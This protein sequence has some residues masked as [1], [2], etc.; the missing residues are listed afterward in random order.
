MVT[1]MPA[2]RISGPDTRDRLASL[3]G[4]R[5]WAALVVVLYH[6]SRLTGKLPLISDV[7]W[8]GRTGVTFFFVLSGFVLAWT[9]DGK[10]V[11]AAVFLWRRFARIWP[12][13]AVSTIVSVTV[14]R[15]LGTDFSWRGVAATLGL[16]NSWAP[17]RAYL[18]GGN[19]A[20]WSLSDEAWFYLLFPLLLMLP[21]LRSARGRTWCAVVL[22]LASAAVWVSG[23][24][25][26]EPSLRVW[27]LD[28]FPP[29]RTLQFVLGVVAGLAVKRGWRPPVGL[30]VAIALVVAGHIA[31]VPWSR[32]VTDSLWY[33]P[34]SA[35]HL[36]SAP[37]FALLVAAAARADLEG[38][39]TGLS[40]PWTVRLGQ[41]SFAWYL[42][43]EIVIRALLGVLGRPVTQLETARIW[44]L[45]LVISLAVAAVAYHWVE[46]PLER[47]LR[48]AGP[49]GA[50]RAAPAGSPDP[51]GSTPR[52]PHVP[53]PGTP[54]LEKKSVQ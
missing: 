39:R 36:L 27:A 29:T 37:L 45:T 53:G 41:W 4:L 2:S 54:A 25:F 8:Y 26:T 32:A 52:E 19:P 11:P 23:S 49:G 15:V 47:L 3:T 12:L 16:I 1:S 10:T 22:C 40:G 14:W 51:G 21:L 17:G 18:V 13:L 24:L 34:Y 48:R 33:S 35:S 5:F 9:Y 7:T 50:R 46:H 28:Y 6:L 38:R 20:A 44:L 43:H 30:P 42:F 31:L